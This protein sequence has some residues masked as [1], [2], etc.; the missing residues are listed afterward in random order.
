MKNI[1]LGMFI[2]FL[3]FGCGLKVIDPNKSNTTGM[4]Q[5]DISDGS[6]K[7]VDTYT[8]TMVG[9]AN[10]TRVYANGKTEE[11]ARKE[12]IAKCQSMSVISFCTISKI[13]CEKN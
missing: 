11:E 10:A 13:S 3:M 4:K 2:P 6:L 8:C 7:L 9:G 12:V 1:F 5:V